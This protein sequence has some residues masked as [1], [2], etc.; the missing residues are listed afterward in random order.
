VRRPANARSLLFSIRPRNVFRVLQALPGSEALLRGFLRYV[1]GRPD[2]K[3]RFIGGVAR[4][5]VSTL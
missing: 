1:N 5:F 4:A 2:L 3:L